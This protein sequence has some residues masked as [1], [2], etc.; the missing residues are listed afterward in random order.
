MKAGELRQ[1]FQFAF[2]VETDDGLGNKQG[3]WIDQFTVWAKHATLRAGESVMAG[4]LTGRA[5]AIVTIRY[6]IQAAAITTDWR[7]TDTRSG[8]IYNIRQVMPGEK[9]DFIELLVEAGVAA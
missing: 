7:C 6:S 2:R 8:A 5:P 1:R 4:R 3:E 9:R